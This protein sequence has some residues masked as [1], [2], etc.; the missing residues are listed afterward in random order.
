MTMGNKSGGKKQLS[1]K[2]M[3]ETADYVNPAIMRYLNYVRN[4]RSDVYGAVA[5][6]PLVRLGKKMDAPM[7]R[8]LLVRLG[9]EVCG[10]TDYLGIVPLCAAVELLNISTYVIDDIFDE[11]DYR[12]KKETVHRIY[13]SNRAF[14]A[15]MLL[16]ELGEKA[17]CDV[18]NAVGGEDFAKIVR[19]FNDTH[20]TIYE[21]QFHDLDLN[22]FRDVGEGEYF[23]RTYEITGVF[24]ENCILLG[25]H[26]A[27]ADEAMLKALSEY[28]RNYG[29]AIQ[30]RN[31]LLDFI[32]PQPE[33]AEKDIAESSGIKGESHVDFRQGKKTL[34]LIHFLERASSE[35][36]AIL[37][38]FVGRKKLARE[39]ALEVNRLLESTGSFE[40]AKQKVR[41]YAARALESLDAFDE[42][43][44][45][46]ALA[47]L[48]VITDNVDKW[49]F[50]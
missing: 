43:T 6:L 38:S 17:L 33:V 2:L 20:K 3:R 35:Q 10:G 15:G 21:G 42:N 44:A 27:G 34:P 49:K 50:V 12:Q 29:I 13:G 1:M 36:Q 11:C 5:H 32:P 28:G 16:R 31:D 41:E 18:E 9:Y 7:L 4:G 47:E 40:Y 46:S 23:T 19:L 26:A 39:E 14:I 24:I 30:L 37:K 25:A 45:K 8:P 22:T 48:A